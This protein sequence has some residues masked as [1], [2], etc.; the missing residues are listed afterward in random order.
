[1]LHIVNFVLNL[2]LINLQVFNCTGKFSTYE[3]FFL[4]VFNCQAY[5][6][7]KWPNKQINNLIKQNVKTH[8]HKLSR[9]W[10]KQCDFVINEILQSNSSPV[11]CVEEHIK[12]IN[13][14]YF[15]STVKF[16]LCGNVHPLFL[17]HLYF[18]FSHDND[19]GENLALCFTNLT[20]ISTPRSPSPVLCESA[21]AEVE[22]GQQSERATTKLHNRFYPLSNSYKPQVGRLSSLKAQL[23]MF[24]FHIDMNIVELEYFSNL[25]AGFLVC[26]CPPTCWR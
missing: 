9:T 7:F 20:A 14:C 15:N 13:P 19:E 21:E 16:P 22:V 6:E 26:Y 23:L 11:T 17:K 24:A 3:D 25:I 5:S 1:M 8:F 4:F 2:L 18:S 10:S 12:K